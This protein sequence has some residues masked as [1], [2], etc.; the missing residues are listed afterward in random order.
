VPPNTLKK[1]DACDYWRAGAIIS[2]VLFHAG[3]L[4]YGYLGVDLFFVLSGFLVSQSLLKQI[5]ENGAIK[6]MPFFISRA[7]K[8]WP[9]YFSF[10]LLGNLS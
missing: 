10:L 4:P 1:I 6:F 2:V 9:M 8:I 7:F 5:Q 3:C